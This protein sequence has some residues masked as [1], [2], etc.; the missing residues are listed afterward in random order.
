M[1]NRALITFSIACPAIFAAVLAAQQSQPAAQPGNADIAGLPAGRGIYYHAAP[2]W[3]ALQSKLLVPFS[4]GSR[5]L[6]FLNLGSTHS[7]AEMAGPHAAVQIGNARPTF[8]LRGITPAELY[9]VR[10][11]PKTDYRELWMANGRN[12]REWAHYRSEDVTGIDTQTVGG[13]VVTV[14]PRA[15]LKPGEY[16][17]ASTLEPGERW[18]RLGYDFGLVG[19]TGQ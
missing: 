13:D 10:S 17:L 2:G 12:F 11:I 19:R 15:D 3:V 18:I 1:T 8:Y 7:I 4:D 5:V 16:A 9:L 14:K 6:N